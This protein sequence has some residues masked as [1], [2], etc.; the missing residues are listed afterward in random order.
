MG[1]KSPCKDC[2]KVGCGAYHDSCEKFLEYKKSK[3]KE[4][5]YIIESVQIRQDIRS[6]IER[7]KRRGK[8]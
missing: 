1:C 5:G 3:K 8:R 2:E 4:H 7:M 6:G